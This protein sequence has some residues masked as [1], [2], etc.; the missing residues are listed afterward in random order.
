MLATL[1][2]LVAHNG[3]AN[4]AMLAAIAGNAAAATD[5]EILDLLHHVLVAN[6]FWLVTVLDQPFDYPHESRPAASLAEL[7]QRCQATHEQQAAWLAGA[8]DADIARTLTNPLIPSGQCSVAQAFMQVCMHSHGHR[9][10]CAKLL[11][12]HGTVPPQ[13]DFITWLAERPAAA[14]S[15]S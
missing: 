6:R 3:H 10:Q 15:G 5:R 13:T 9:A 11:R 14:T 7:R 4:A 1:R 8:S 12:R 2:D